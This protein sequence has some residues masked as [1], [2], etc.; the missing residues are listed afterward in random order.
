MSALPTMVP[1]RWL[2]RLPGR[3]DNAWSLLGLQAGPGAA[4]VS[5]LVLS[6]VSGMLLS[7]SVA[8][9]THALLSMVLLPARGSQVAGGSSAV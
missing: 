5:H 8:L 9:Q 6:T 4:S 1:K 3:P 2:A 7:C